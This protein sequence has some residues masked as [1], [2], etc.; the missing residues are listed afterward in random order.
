MGW[1]RAMKPPKTP[2]PTG[3]LLHVYCFQVEVQNISTHFH[4]HVYVSEY[5]SYVGNITVLL[6]KSTISANPRLVN[7]LNYARTCVYDVY[8]GTPPPI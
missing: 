1:A 8:I 5:A 3:L 4:I 7:E 2:I 6:N